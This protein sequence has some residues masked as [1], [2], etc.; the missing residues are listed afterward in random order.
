MYYINETKKA[1][2]YHCSTKNDVPGKPSI[3]FYTEIYKVGNE[4]YASLYIVHI[5]VLTFQFALKFLLKK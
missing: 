5:W 3:N 2:I 1:S 4:I